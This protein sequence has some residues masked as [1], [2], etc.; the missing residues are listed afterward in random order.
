MTWVPWPLPMRSRTEA[1]PDR[2]RRHVKEA[3]SVARA[4]T[5]AIGSN[6]GPPAT[7][8]ERRPIGPYQALRETPRAAQPLA[9]SKCDANGT[10]LRGQTS[11]S[12]LREASA[13]EDISLVAPSGSDVLVTVRVRAL[14]HP[15][16]SRH[17]RQTHTRSPLTRMR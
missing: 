4:S 2:R 10:T 3:S 13:P 17:W 15:R 12:W 16:L 7:Q 6:K 14:H 8:G 5:A 11:T 1:Q 9:L